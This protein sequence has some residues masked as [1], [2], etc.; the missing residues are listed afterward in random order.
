MF[1]LGIILF[2]LYVG[3]PPF[4]VASDDD[5]YYKLLAQN[6]SDMFWKAHCSKKEPGFFS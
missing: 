4:S 6:R 3:Y 5:G 1:A 2:I